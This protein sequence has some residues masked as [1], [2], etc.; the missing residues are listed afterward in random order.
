MRFLHHIL[1]VATAVLTVCACSDDNYQQA[2]LPNNQSQ[3]L[4]LEETEIPPLGGVRDVAFTADSE[5][6]LTVEGDWLNPNKRSG[7]AGTTVVQFNI[8]VNDSWEDRTAK[9]I[10]RA[11]D[12]SFNKEFEITQACPYLRLIDQNGK[13]W[14]NRGTTRR[15]PIVVTEGSDQYIE[16][17]WNFCEQRGGDRRSFSIESNIDWQVVLV[18]QDDFFR[19]SSGL[20]INGE[21]LTEPMSFKNNEVLELLPISQNIDTQKHLIHIRIQAL[22]S[23]KNMAAM[24]PE[25]LNVYDLTIDQDYLIFL[26]DKSSAECNQ[27]LSELTPHYDTGASKTIQVHTEVNWAVDR[28]YVDANKQSFP[29]WLSVSPLSARANDVTKS[30]EESFTNL[31]IST[32]TLNP[33]KN[34]HSYTMR[35]FDEV[36][37]AERFINVSRNPYTFELSEGSRTPVEFENEDSSVKEIQIITSGPWHFSN[38]PDWLQISKVVD[39][40][41]SLIDR[42]EYSYETGQ[43]EYSDEYVG[44]AVISYF[45]P[46]QNLNFS[47]LS[48]MITV[49]PNMD[50]HSFDEESIS[51]S[52]KPF[53]FNIAEERVWDG[54]EYTMSNLED[55][56]SRD[57]S[58]HMINLETSGEWDVTVVDKQTNRVTNWLKVPKR[59]EDAQNPN[60]IAVTPTSANP[61]LSRDRAAIITFVSRRHK[62]AVNAHVISSM[63]PQATVSIEAKQSAYIFN[64]G[65]NENVD[66]KQLDVDLNTTLKIPAY[67]KTPN[68]YSFVVKCSED[69]VR[70][71][72]SPSWMQRVQ[73]MS[74]NAVRGVPSTTKTFQYR[75][76]TNTSSSP[77]TGK[78]VIECY[79]NDGT[80]STASVEQKVINVMQDGFVFSLAD[81]TEAVDDPVNVNTKTV[82]F[83]LTPEVQWTATPSSGWIITSQ[84]G[85][86]SPADG[87]VKFT[88][89]PEQNATNSD[90]SG[91]VTVQVEPQVIDN[92]YAKISLSQKKY[93]FDS[94]PFAAPASYPEMGTD[95]GAI[96]KYSFNVTSSGA[97]HIV[98]KPDWVTVS[99]DKG[100]GNKEGVQ[101]TVSANPETTSR[102]KM[103]QVR[104]DVLDLE[105]NGSKSTEALTKNVTV[106]QDAY[107]WDISSES[108]YSF[109][110]VDDGAKIIKVKS[111]GPWTITSPDDWVVATPSSGPGNQDGSYTDVTILPKHNR[112]EN[113]RSGS[114]V[115]SADINA[116]KLK[117]TAN[118]SQTMFILS[119]DKSSITT[120]GALDVTPKESNVSSSTGNWSVISSDNRV[121]QVSAG[122]GKVII[123]PVKNVTKSRR[124]ATVTL[125]NSDCDFTKTILV[126]QP[127]Y[128]FETLS[129]PSEYSV[130]PAASKYIAV[131]ASPLATWNYSI[132]E[133]S[134]IIS[135]HSQTYDNGLNGNGRINIACS[136]NLT[137]SARTAKVRITS[138]DNPSYTI[139]VP[140][141]QEAFKFSVSPTQS[142]QTATEMK[143]ETFNIVSSGSWQLQ[144]DASWINM[145][146]DSG[147]GSGSF[148]V[149]PTT[150]NTSLT[151]P[152]TATITLHC[153]IPGVTF[154]DEIITITQSKYV[155]EVN[156]TSVPSLLPA[157]GASAINVPITCSG[158]WSASIVS[159][160]DM[161]SINKTSN[162][163]LAITPKNNTTSSPRTAKVRVISDDGGHTQDIDLSQEAYSFS[164]SDMSEEQFLATGGQR[165]FSITTGNNCSWQVA[166]PSA[167]TL[168]K[169]SG[170]GSATITVTVS[171][172]KSKTDQNY[173][174]VTVKSVDQN[175]EYKSF[176]ITQK[177]YV[178]SFDTSTKNCA[179]VN[180]SDISVAVSSSGDWKV[181]TTSNPGNMIS[182]VQRNGNNAVV[183][184]NTNTSYSSRQ[185]TIKLSTTDGSGFSGTFS[186]NQAAA[187]PPVE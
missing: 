148:R 73:Q 7:K 60:R 45:A 117:K 84:T 167:V 118:V 38:V 110:P 150:S 79:Y 138:N 163:N 42:K 28:L 155:F 32:N 76:T 11:T 37:G 120:D 9:V 29:D 131:E 151:E 135:S 49:S 159:G 174:Y 24:G 100:N 177:A 109:G 186:I 180:P 104:A 165:S 15:E 85:G 63:P 124:Q 173:G 19:E 91:T 30:P 184:V 144:K 78:F 16:Y 53:V 111:S 130:L 176:A 23:Q 136:N 69:N 44:N 46:E 75:M 108:A 172:N 154:S 68:V 98:D 59:S 143:T 87:K 171:P 70:V 149:T 43:R 102:T 67:K 166:A 101:V 126:T 142:T 178:F 152:R 92:K 2:S 36:S 134:S 146:T 153:T 122:T 183:K 139:D 64:V 127:E 74:S 140:I 80:S 40:G 1:I 8:D 103:F 105:L 13:R 72:E 34:S 3:S 39:S 169:S 66:G 14:D 141:S 112:S 157:I 115:V 71:V 62:N 132:V 129:V 5:W 41:S 33:D 6:T 121:L 51:V 114:F 113:N 21:V 88:I 86:V 119:L 54:T 57:M 89:T 99:P 116:A 106:K 125:K 35:L 168:N 145:S 137:K 61:D 95:A 93:V 162:T 25:A 17:D 181:E 175:R 179:A 52:Q 50:R 47:Q 31:T 22:N 58:D 65:G 164:V 170:K 27:T 96:V 10:F 55:M 94:S 97:W 81:R 160:S 133:G 26:L 158:A 82:E 90:R 107:K 77:R 128:V 187:T 182:S 4:S 56:L 48:G 123:T 20:K 147:S 18:D 161:V 156:R 83:D 185:A 12:G